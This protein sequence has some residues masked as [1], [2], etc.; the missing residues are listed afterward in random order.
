MGI[1][2]VALVKRKSKYEV[3]PEILR[4]WSPRKMSGEKISVKELNTL[5][6]AARWAPSSFN[7]QPWRFVYAKKG[8]KHWNTLFNLLVPFNQEWC[9]N[10]AVLVL[11][12]SRNNFEHNEK[13]ANTH[14]FDTGSAWENLAIQAGSMGL[15]A[16]GMA[17]FDYDKARKTLKI[18]KEYTVECMISIG[19]PSKEISKEEITKRKPLKDIVSEGLFKWN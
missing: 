17:G 5:F 3:L 7:G 19:K 1:K 6:E 13:P 11:V 18:P 12:V 9:R 15:V 4:R 16:H 2:D 14:S 10:A 8:G